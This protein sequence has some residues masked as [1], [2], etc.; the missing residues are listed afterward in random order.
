MN[1]DE[2][3]AGMLAITATTPPEPAFVERLV[4]HMVDVGPATMYPLIGRMF[5]K[6]AAAPG[7]AGREA[8]QAL[9]LALAKSPDFE[10]AMKR[11]HAWRAEQPKTEATP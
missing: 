5:D 1:D 8:L 6:A 7:T 11:L 3:F 4:R 10:A 2:I 9:N